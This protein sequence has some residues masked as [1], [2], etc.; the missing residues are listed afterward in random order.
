MR[1]VVAFLLCLGPALAQDAPPTFTVSVEQGWRLSADTEVDFPNI[2]ENDLVAGLT[3]K[4]TL[5]TSMN[6]PMR[7]REGRVMTKPTLSAAWKTNGD[8]VKIDATMAVFPDGGC[9]LTLKK[10]DSSDRSNR[11]TIE[12]DADKVRT[13][14]LGG[15]GKW[16]GSRKEWSGRV[17]ILEAAL[18]ETYLKATTPQKSAAGKDSVGLDIAGDTKAAWRLYVTTSI[19]DQL[20]ILILCRLDGIRVEPEKWLTEIADGPERPKALARALIDRIQAQA[21]G[22]FATEPAKAKPGAT[23]K[24]Q[25]WK[26]TELAVPYPGWMDGRAWCAERLKPVDDAKERLRGMTVE[27]NGKN[28][29]TM[30]TRILDPGVWRSAVEDEAKKLRQMVPVEVPGKAPSFTDALLPRTHVGGTPTYD[31][32]EKS[33]AKDGQ[34]QSSEAD[35]AGIIKDFEVIFFCSGGDMNVWRTSTIRLETWYKAKIKRD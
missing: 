19:E 12:L 29:T 17:G 8:P 9:T 15:K 33:V 30:R 34:V 16:S 28:S 11:C 21:R 23:L 2:Q 26:G 7:D 35:V 3:P 6:W 4:F 24:D 32:K 27:T 1:V 10:V 13:V 25:P 20:A 31:Y 18:R 14:D 22:T 5:K